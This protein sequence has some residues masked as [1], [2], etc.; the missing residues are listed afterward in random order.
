MST[1]VGK[2]NGCRYTGFRLAFIH[3]R[4]WH[5]A[6]LNMIVIHIVH[7]TV[8]YSL[9]HHINKMNYVRWKWKVANPPYCIFVCGVCLLLKL[10]SMEYILPLWLHY[11]VMRSFEVCFVVS[12]N[13]LWKTCMLIITVTSQWAQWRLKSPIYRLF[14]QPF[15]QAHIKGN[16]AAALH[17]PLAFVTGIHWWLT[18]NAENC[19]HLMTP[20]W[21]RNETP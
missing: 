21:W 13:N 2:Y 15:I 9:L 10:K 7:C 16:I 1:I 20:S 3:P 8:A 4:P 18:S 6:N 19:F 11:V 14:A 12:L 17:W 5:N